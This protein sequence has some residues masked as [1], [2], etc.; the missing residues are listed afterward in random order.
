MEHS[1]HGG[2]NDADATVET[3]ETEAVHV[4]EGANVDRYDR[5]CI[6][7]MSSHLHVPFELPLLASRKHP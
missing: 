2:F 5:C 3:K 1:V 7:G 6:A 4:L